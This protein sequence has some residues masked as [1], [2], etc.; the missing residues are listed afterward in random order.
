M[1]AGDGSK[2]LLEGSRRIHSNIDE[3]TLH[4]E[5]RPFGLF[6]LNVLDR[7]RESLVTSPGGPSVGTRDRSR[8]CP[9]E[10]DRDR[11]AAN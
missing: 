3:A 7:V 10:R 6:R 9:R 4:E 2:G 5:E 11:G 8:G 1:S